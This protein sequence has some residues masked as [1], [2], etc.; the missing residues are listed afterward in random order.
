MGDLAPEGVV[1]FVAGL[2]VGGVA[3]R[4]VLR[5]FSHQEPQRPSR[6]IR[7]ASAGQQ[8]RQGR[9]GRQGQLRDARSEIA[10][11]LMAVT[12]QTTKRK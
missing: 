12:S 8:G 5:A 9:Q 10:R 6:A 3:M 1:Q 11:L 7:G 4:L 2:L